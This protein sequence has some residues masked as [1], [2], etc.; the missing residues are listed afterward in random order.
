MLVVPSAGHAA[1]PDGAHEGTLVRQTVTFAGRLSQHRYSLREDAGASLLSLVFDSPPAVKS[2]ARLR[3]WG[4]LTGDELRVT[5]YEVMESLARAALRD[6]RSL[7][8]AGHEAP[9]QDTYALVLVNVGQNVD[10]TTAQAQT[11]FFSTTPSDSSFYEVY[12]ES[13]FGQYLI[14]G[15]VVGPL[16]YPDTSCNTCGMVNT[17][18]G[19]ITKKYNHYVYYIGPGDS[20]GFGG[21]GDEGTWQSPAQDTWLNDSLDCGAMLQE[22]GHNLGWNHSG[23]MSCS[24]ASFSSTA[25]S[26]TID[27]YGDPMS[28]MGNGCNQFNAYEKWYQNWLSGCNAVKVQSSGTFNLVPHET[29]CAGAV[30]VLQIPLP[31]AQTIQDPQDGAWQLKYYYVELRAPIGVDAN[32]SASVWIYVAD[33]AV[34]PKDQ[35]SHTY[36][37]DMNPQTHNFDPLAQ[38]QT[39]TDPGGAI[40]IT[41]TSVSATGA[42]IQVTVPGSGGNACIDGTM[43]MGSG[44]TA[45]TSSGSSSGSGGSSGSSSGSS[46]GGSS[47]SSSGTTSGSSSGSSSSGSGS[48]SG[49][50]SSGS[51]G[52]GSGSASSG[53]S[54]SGSSSSTSSGSSGSSGSGSGVAGSSGGPGLG[55]GDAGGNGGNL[56]AQGNA[57]A[58]CACQTTGARPRA[59]S[60]W[61]T[62]ALFGGFWTARRRRRANAGRR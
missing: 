15:D 31:S 57:S 40:K 59:A 53:S 36:L 2:G 37:L 60:G 46:S 47:G 3:V 9:M 23:T 32:L 18:Q 44:P 27:E 1:A 56:W 30:Q 14:S 6:G 11:A 43:L 8:P 42:T 24:G 16:T 39:Y 7:G 61:G 55:A 25:S 5:R 41:A 58:G 48:S 21:L 20:C 33:E 17:L 19:M 38:G 52:S 51:S 28:P 29:Q 50:S 54:G 26:C 4:D 13:S 22:P 10:V 34:I 45:C 35:A 62:L 12:K 49:G